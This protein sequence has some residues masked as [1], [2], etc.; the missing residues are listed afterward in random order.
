MNP[1]SELVIVEDPDIIENIPFFETEVTTTAVCVLLVA[2]LCGKL[3]HYL[4]QRGGSSLVFPPPVT[5]GVLCIGF[6]VAGDLG[7]CESCTGVMDLWK[8][9]LDVLVNCVC[10]SLFFSFD[11]IHRPFKRIWH[12]IIIQLMYGQVVSWGQYGV[13]TLTAM[14]FC[15]IDP[16]KYTPYMGS[17]VAMGMEGGQRPMYNLNTKGI[18]T[19]V[20]QEFPEAYAYAVSASNIGML[21]SFCVGIVLLSW[22][23]VWDTSAVAGEPHRPT[24]KSVDMR[25]VSFKHERDRKLVFESLTV[26]LGIIALSVGISF[27]ISFGFV[28][29]ENAVTDEAFAEYVE[30]VL[31]S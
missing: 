21:V 26:H 12:E 2:V 28:A 9:S 17:I 16:E 3:V 30:H 24:T 4:L 10:A 18:F 20:H 27:A 19:E 31:G 29:L 15:A 1:N 11:L 23:K 6:A 13:C 14:I 22:K 8:L 25:L 5:A 7:V